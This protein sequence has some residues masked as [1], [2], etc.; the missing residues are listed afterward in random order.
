MLPSYRF[1]VTD[2]AKKKG[3]MRVKSAEDILLKVRTN[4]LLKDP[5]YA[6]LGSRLVHEAT[7]DIPVMATDGVRLLYNPAW[8]QSNPRDVVEGVLLHEYLHPILLHPFRAQ[9]L[10]LEHG[11]ANMAG[12]YVVNNIVLQAGKKLPKGGLINPAFEGKSLEEVYRLLPTKQDGQEGSKGKDG[13]GDDFGG[14]GKFD[15]PPKNDKG[16]GQDKG[17][18]QGSPGGPD[19]ERQWKQ[20][21]VQAAQLSKGRGSLPAEIQ[22]MV[23]EITNPPVDGWEV[24]EQFVVAAA[25]KDDYKWFPSSRRHIWAGNYMPSC[26]SDSLGTLVLAVDTSGSIDNELLRKFVERIMGLAS[27]YRFEAHVIGCDTRVNGV[28]HF[29]RGEDITFKE[30]LEV[31]KGGGGTSF[32]PV[33][34]EVEKRGL[35]PTVLVYFTDMDGRFPDREPGYPV[36]WASYGRDRAPFGQVVSLS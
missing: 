4:L 8:V 29:E 26:V 13:K 34:Q 6:S 25:E 2:E 36:V 7:N 5:F 17:Q 23:E 14:C 19:L 18:A 16:K 35:V 27:V 9:R 1:A 20:A 30:V 12:D 22:R 28:V 15:Q 31:C 24:L 21:V 11:R 3:G 32:I 33:F 10:K